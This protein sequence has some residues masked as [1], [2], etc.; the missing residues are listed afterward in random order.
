MNI[1]QFERTE[2]G[3]L[4]SPWIDMKAAAA[5]LGFC[6][7]SI[8]RACATGGLRHVRIGRNIRTQRP[9]LDAFVISQDARFRRVHDGQVTKGEDCGSRP[10]RGNDGHDNI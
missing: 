9:W 2:A 1:A 6:E 5:Y 7:K 10:R 4:V 3:T 8:R